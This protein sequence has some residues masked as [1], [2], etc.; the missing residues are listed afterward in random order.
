MSFTRAYKSGAIILCALSATLESLV[1]YL[2]GGTDSNESSKGLTLGLVTFSLT[3][4]KA[5]LIFSIN[6]LKGKPRFGWA[7]FFWTESLSPYYVLLHVFKIYEKEQASTFIS[8][9]KAPYHLPCGN[10]KFSPF[11]SSHL[12][13]SFP[14]LWNNDDTD[15][16]W[17]VVLSLPR[18][19]TS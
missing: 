10:Y 16:L 18:I 13:A 1:F 5:L 2:S 12:V 8:D 7:A 6:E 11:T 15:F 3:V 14:L 19:S 4:I 9:T 17:K